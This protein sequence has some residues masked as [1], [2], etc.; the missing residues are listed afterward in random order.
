VSFA[1]KLIFRQLL[2]CKCASIWANFLKMDV[3]LCVCLYVLADCHSAV[4]F[5]V[6]WILGSSSEWLHSSV[7]SML[8]RAADTAL[9]SASL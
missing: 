7:L 9:L 1:C 5:G 4:C 3:A 8:S 2:V 6:H